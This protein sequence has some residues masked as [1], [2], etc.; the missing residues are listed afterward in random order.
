MG[1]T[2]DVS[3]I[4]AR[5]AACAKPPWWRD[6]PPWEGRYRVFEVDCDE[7]WVDPRCPCCRRF[8]RGDT[9]EIFSNMDGASVVFGECSRCGP[10]MPDKD[11]M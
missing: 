4:E 1:R 11:Y 2:V 10:I 9:I 5:K 3:E 7:V 8:Y 6:R